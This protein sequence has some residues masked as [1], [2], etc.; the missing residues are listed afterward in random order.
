M[1]LPFSPPSV[2]VLLLSAFPPRFGLT[3][4]KGSSGWRK[5]SSDSAKKALTDFTNGVVALKL[6]SREYFIAFVSPQS[7]NML[8]NP[9]P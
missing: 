2:K 6:V 5:G 8:P 3:G 9:L 7:Q 1:R 4:K